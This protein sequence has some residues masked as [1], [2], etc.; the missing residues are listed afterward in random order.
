MKHYKTYQKILIYI[1]PLAS[2]VILSLTAWFV[3]NFITFPPCLLYIIT[4]IHCP[5]CGITRA[6]E[7]LLSGNILLAIRQN[8]FLMIYIIT[9]IL[10]YIEI[11]IKIVLERKI[12]FSILNLKYLYAM[13]I[14]IGIYSILRNIF[15]ILAPV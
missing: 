4:G 12:K 8:V 14:L 15:P 1:F 3:L 2:V 10:I 9:A 11:F 13:L 5:S 7:A 6:V